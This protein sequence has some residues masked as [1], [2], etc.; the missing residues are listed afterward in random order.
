MAPANVANG[1]LPV[2][3]TPTD[4][5]S[6]NEQ[7]DEPG[8]SSRIK[9]RVEY[10]GPNNTILYEY[11]TKGPHYE[12]EATSASGSH[13]L[14]ILTTFK[15]LKKDLEW[16]NDT[17]FQ[18]I[19]AAPAR[20]M[21]ILSK[22][23]MHALRSVVL[24]YPSQDLTG[25]VINIASPYT[26]LVHHYDELMEYREKFRP[27]TVEE[28]CHREKDAYEDLGILLAYLDEH[29]MPAVRE[30][31]ARNARGYQTFDLFW[32]SMKPGSH[33]RIENAKDNE[34]SVGIVHSFTGGS[35]STATAQWKINSWNLDYNGEYIGRRMEIGTYSPWDGERPS[36]ALGFNVS[37]QEQDIRTQIAKGTAYWSLIHHKQCKYY[38]GRTRE[39][40]HNEVDAILCPVL[41]M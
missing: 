38:K 20:S 35:L 5:Q 27:G 13:V 7:A 19:G 39:F 17:K 37:S 29:I 23:V 36:L 28:F 24:Y 26:V 25:D 1:A 14:E 2:A 12:D 15:T 16:N 21:R 22:A 4:Q 31:Q 18:S 32:V 30:E 3:Q 11:E 8:H 41:W 34:A 40:P 6:M 33:I 10:V 9:Y